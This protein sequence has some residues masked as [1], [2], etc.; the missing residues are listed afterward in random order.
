MRGLDVTIVAS[1]ISRS[2]HYPRKLPEKYSGDGE[3]SQYVRSAVFASRTGNIIAVSGA[4][5]DELFS[6]IMR[7]QTFVEASGFVNQE[8]FVE[9][10]L[11]CAPES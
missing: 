3:L 9:K 7:A 11:D 1:G 4:A 6:D 2:S 8:W 5:H 10:G